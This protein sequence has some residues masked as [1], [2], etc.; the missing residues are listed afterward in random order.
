MPIHLFV[1]PL[2]SFLPS[3]HSCP[4]GSLFC[5]A[6][7]RQTPT[8]VNLRRRTQ[9]VHT[10]KRVDPTTDR[11]E[12]TDRR[13]HDRGEPVR[14]WEDTACPSEWALLVASAAFSR[15]TKARRARGQ[16]ASDIRRERATRPAPWTLTLW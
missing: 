7:A 4:L 15:V 3:P 16:S 10:C 5:D 2:P 14:R 12:K 8:K 9:P 1:L 6:A 13:R 11:D